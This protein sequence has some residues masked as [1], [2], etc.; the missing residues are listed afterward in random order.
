[1]IVES[2]PIKQVKCYNANNMLNAHFV[3]SQICDNWSEQV[4]FAQ[5][6]SCEVPYDIIYHPFPFNS[7]YLKTWGVNSPAFRYLKGPLIKF[8]ETKN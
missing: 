2:K 5:M 4:F 3:L 6:M 7:Q 1:M 8:S